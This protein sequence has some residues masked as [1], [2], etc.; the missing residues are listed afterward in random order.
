MMLATAEFGGAKRLKTL[1]PCYQKV[2]YI[3][4]VTL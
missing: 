4:L 3:L 1:Q 2:V